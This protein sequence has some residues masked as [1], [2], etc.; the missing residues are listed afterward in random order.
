MD[1]SIIFFVKFDSI[2]WGMVENNR[3][4]FFTKHGKNCRRH[5]THDIRDCLLAYE[6]MYV[7]NH[8]VYS[9]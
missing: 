6:F 8:I 3:L 7:N 4:I 2:E 9:D 5:S 1:S